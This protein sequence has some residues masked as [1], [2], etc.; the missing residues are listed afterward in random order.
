VGNHVLQLDSSDANRAIQ[1]DPFRDAEERHTL[2]QWACRSK[3]V[4]RLAL[5]AGE[6]YNL[7]GILD[8]MKKG[9]HGSD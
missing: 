1:E 4:Q 3:T 7:S 8:A 5:Q 2:K 6:T 9:A